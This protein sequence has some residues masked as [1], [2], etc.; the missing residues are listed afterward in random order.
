MSTGSFRVWED[1]VYPGTEVLRNKAGLRDAAALER[2]ERG[3]TFGRLVELRAGAVAVTGRF[4]L[5]P[6]AGDPRPRLSGRLRSGPG[7]CAGFLCS[8]ARHLLAEL[9]AGFRPRIHPVL[10]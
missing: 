2:F 6:P 4:D 1:F 8:R 10:R 3:R 9:L 5:A 7:S